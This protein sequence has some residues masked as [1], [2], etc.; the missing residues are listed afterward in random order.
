MC[1]VASFVDERITYKLIL[2]GFTTNNLFLSKSKPQRGAILQNQR[3][4][5]NIK[6]K[7]ACV[8]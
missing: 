6:D 5:E 4:V 7:V 3:N 8:Y 2:I 1:T